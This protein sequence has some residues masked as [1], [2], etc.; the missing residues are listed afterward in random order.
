MPPT[1]I[2][3]GVVVIKF[4]VGIVCA[5]PNIDVAV[6]PVFADVAAVRLNTEEPGLA[7]PEPQ[8][9]AVI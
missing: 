6:V 2:L 4:P 7:E 5:P 9:D 3:I 1:L 8:S